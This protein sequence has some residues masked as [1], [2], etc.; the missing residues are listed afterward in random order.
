MLDMARL[1]RFPQQTKKAW[2]IRLLRMPFE[3]EQSGWPERVGE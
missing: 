2:F 3:A 1:A